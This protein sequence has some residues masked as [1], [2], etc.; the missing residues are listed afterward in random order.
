MYNDRIIQLTEDG[1]HTIAIPVMNVTYHSRH[2][3]MQES[4][5][6]FIQSG[7]RYFIS[8]NEPLSSKT[9]QIFEQ[10]FGTGLN[11][12]LSLHE[13]IQTGQKISY[14]TIEPYPVTIE[15]AAQLNYGDIINKDLK[16]YFYQLHACEWN[17]EVWIHPLFSFKK[18]NVALRQLEIP[19]Q[20]HIIYFDAFDPEA[21]PELWTE[22]IFK[23]MCDLLYPNGIL[24]TYSSKGKVQRAMKAAGFSIEKLKGPPGKREIIRA[25]KI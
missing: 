13:A 11:A 9:I 12:L 20:F 4:I 19:E 23:K 22:F 24:V 6:V 16:E 8:N 18:I 17:K 2:G 7:L 25:L 1:S 10:G 3:A 21:Q 15:E 5:H 14:H